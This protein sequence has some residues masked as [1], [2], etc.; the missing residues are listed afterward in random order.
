MNPACWLASL[1]FLGCG[2][3]E[4]PSLT[5]LDAGVDVGSDRGAGPKILA[6]G[7]WGIARIAIDDEAVYVM[8]APSG[9]LW[10]VPKDGSAAS[11]LARVAFV[12]AP[13]ALD[14]EYAYWSDN[15]DK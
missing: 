6:S 2:R 12:A 10:R 4:E 7:P 13:P 8:S 15:P 11:E 9:G 14:G 1:I 3:V 5:P